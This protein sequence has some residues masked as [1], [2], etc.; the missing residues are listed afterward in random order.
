MSLVHIERSE[1]ANGML[2]SE[3]I[4][5]QLEQGK[6]IAFDHIP[7]DIPDEH[8]R[9][10]LSARQENTRL[11]KNISFRPEQKVVRGFSTKEDSEMMLEIMQNYS[12]MA[13]RFLSGFLAPYAAGWSLDYASFRPIEEAGRQ[14]PLHKRNDLL[15]VDAFPSR[16]THGGRI[17]RFFSNINPAAD[18]VWEIGEGFGDVAQ[19][20]AAGAGLDRIAKRSLSPFGKAVD[21]LGSAA[22]AIGMPVPDRSAYDRFMLGFHDHLKESLEF[23]AEAKKTRIDYPPNSTWMVFTDCVPHSVLSGQFALEQTFIIPVASLVAPED[24]PLRILE[25]LCGS[26]LVNN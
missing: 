25:R 11:H 14:L 22:R 20:Y 18:R 21:G 9:F 24:S 10:L 15:H 13:V 2:K 16:P 1:I 23:R 3:D 4:C 5:R 6:I 26:K 8:I 17:L 7:F 12:A 19:Q